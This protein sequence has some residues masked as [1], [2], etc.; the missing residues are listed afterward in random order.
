M[1]PATY[2]NIEYTYKKWSIFKRIRVF[3]Q[4]GCKYKDLLEIRRR[5]DNV[6]SAIYAGPNVMRGLSEFE[7]VSIYKHRGSRKLD[8][9]YP[10]NHAG[11]E[12]NIPDFVYASAE[13]MPHNKNKKWR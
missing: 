11:R 9:N 3:L 6:P 4:T 1:K 7:V 12:T 2:N 8:V 13:R 5:L 10:N